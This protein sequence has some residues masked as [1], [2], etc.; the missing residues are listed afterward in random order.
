MFLGK[1]SIA[2]VDYSILDNKINKRAY[3][4]SDVKDKIEKIGFDI[5]RFKDGDTRAELWQIQNS[6]DGDYIVALYQEDNQEKIGNNWNVALSKISGNI[7]ISYKGDPLLV[8]SSNKLG[9]SKSEINKIEEYLPIKL[10]ENKSLVKALLNELNE[11]T[12]K[13]VLNK[14]PELF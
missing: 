7:Q 6:D 8:M 12:K 11:T 14:Y 4:L 2:Q 1:K 9:I 13:D 3:R 5:V 10:S